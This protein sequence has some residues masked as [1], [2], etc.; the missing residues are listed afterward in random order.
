MIRT[1]NCWRIVT[2]WTRLWFDFLIFRQRLVIT[3]FFIL[4]LK[5]CRTITV[6]CLIFLVIYIT[7]HVIYSSR[8][9]C[10]RINI[11]FKHSCRTIN[12]T[13]YG[14]LRIV[15]FIYSKFTTIRIDN[16][17][18]FIIKQNTLNTFWSYVLHLFCRYCLCV[19]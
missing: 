13:L 2:V 5:Y 11:Q 7:I 18:S 6:R 8:V 9:R 4:K 12:S 16:P 1:C 15:G 10:Y 17:G 3:L 14:K 19:V